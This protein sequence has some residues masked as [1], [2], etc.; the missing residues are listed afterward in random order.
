MKLIRWTRHRS[1]CNLCGEAP[2]PGRDSKE[3]ARE[4]RDRNKKSSRATSGHVPGK[5]KQLA[6]VALSLRSGAVR[7]GFLRGLN[8][9]CARMK[10]FSLGWVSFAAPPNSVWMGVVVCFLSK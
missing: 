10:C 5:L 7:C 6:R 4:K 2:P 1:Q 8:R 9:L 3:F